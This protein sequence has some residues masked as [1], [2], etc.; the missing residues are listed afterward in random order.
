[1]R[2]RRHPPGQRSHRSHGNET[3][4]SREAE[5]RQPNRLRQRRASLLVSVYKFT[6]ATI[7]VPIEPFAKLAGTLEFPADFDDF[8]R[9][10]L[11]TGAATRYGV[12]ARSNVW[13]RFQGELF[14][15]LAEEVG[16]FLENHRTLVRILDLVEVERFVATHRCVPGRPLENCRALA[17]AEGEEW[18]C[19]FA[20]SGVHNP[21]QNVSPPSPAF[22]FSS[23][24]GGSI[25]LT[26]KGSISLNFSYTDPSPRASRRVSSNAFQLTWG[27]PSR[28]GKSP[29]GTTVKPAA[30]ASATNSGAEM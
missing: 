23:F 6:V 20:A 26:K 30:W 7:V 8:A 18:S 21:T 3:G 1:M 13:N 28:S 24:A 12:V 9:V 15:V 2:G 25:V 14:R 29:R 22:Q 27:R 11:E 16:P 19:R 17:R 4:R 10:M 5:V